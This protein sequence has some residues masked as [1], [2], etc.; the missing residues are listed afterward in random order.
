[1][2]LSSFGVF[3][4]G[5][6]PSM[7][8]FENWT[9]GTIPWVTSKDMKHRVIKD[10]EMHISE[11]AAASMKKYPAGTLLLVA[12]SG[13]LRRLLPLCILGVDSTINQDIKAFDLYDLSISN[14]LFYALKAFEPMILHN[15]VKSVTTVESLKF[16][17]FSGM[18]IPVPPLN[19]QG[20]I[21][22]AIHTFIILIKPLYDDPLFSL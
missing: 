3:S 19:E 8:D 15:L 5:K 4:S 10:S 6:T 20:K 9:D 21:V 16:D 18:L 13:I 14:W 11:S 22:E 1:M 12:R 7:S 17:E 2:R